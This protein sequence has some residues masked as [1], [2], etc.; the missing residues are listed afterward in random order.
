MDSLV[1]QQ[2]RNRKEL[3]NMKM[4]V[5]N[6]KTN[7]IIFINDGSFKIDFDGLTFESQTDLIEYIENTIKET[8]ANIGLMNQYNENDIR[9]AALDIYVAQSHR[10]KEE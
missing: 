7:S 3:I 10:I 9:I 6:Y 8:L 1:A 2:K 4:E 5:K